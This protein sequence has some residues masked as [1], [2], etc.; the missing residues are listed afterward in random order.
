DKRGANQVRPVAVE[1]AVVFVESS[2]ESVAIAQL[3]GNVYL[4]WTVRAISAL[5]AHLIQTPIKLCGPSL[6]SP[7]PEKYFFAVNADGSLV[8]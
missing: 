6:Y 2:G 3:S 4:K 5:H 1:D 7:L 8:S